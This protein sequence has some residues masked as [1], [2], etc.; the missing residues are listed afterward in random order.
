MLASALAVVLIGVAGCS[1]D[2]KSDPTPAAQNKAPDKVTYLTAFGAVGRDAF[3][4]VAQEKGY[5]KEAGLDVDIQL[6]AATGENLKGLA[7][8]KA[9]FANLDLIGAWILA[10][11]GEYKDFRAIAAIHQQ[12]LVS[13]VA[14]EGGGITAP[15]DLEGKKLGAATGSV[16]QLLFP[17]YAKLA[18]IDPTKIQ[19]VNAQP[20]QLPALLAGGQVQA[21]STF[22]IGSK[23]I[24]KA[25]GG[26]KSVVLPY[27][28][29][30]GDLYGNGIIT[31][32]KIAKEN[33]DLAKRFRDASLKALKYTIEHPDDAAQILKKAQPAA[34]VTAAI[35]EITL[36]TP[37]VTSG[38]A[39][40]VMD[41][42]RV[43]RA[44]ATL[45]A[46]ELIPAGLTPDSVVDFSI[47]PKA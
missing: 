41:Q 8:G 42:E 3:A 31:T 44:I 38:S 19:W 5:F 33:P 28:K 17:G 2:S 12:T 32:S 1:S 24:E 39:I 23:G 15:K 40:G 36:M 18:G 9:Q 34:D 37:Y 29:Y 13:I 21:L 22:L 47:T 14:L 35:G 10:G 6:G 7:S 45:Q 27:S 26:K 46:S 25:A 43:A 16:N 4:W 11:K 30:L 20:A